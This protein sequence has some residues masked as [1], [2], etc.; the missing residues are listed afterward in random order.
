M[1]EEE[2][3]LTDGTHK[4]AIFRVLKEAGSAGFTLAQ[5]VETAQ[6]LG[7]KDYTDKS[8]K[9][10][11]SVCPL[12]TTETYLVDPITTHKTFLW[13]CLPVLRF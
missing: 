8:R 9:H 4:A 6:R 1:Q 7:L 2:A 11:G 3:K 5:I 13:A 10:I 12:P